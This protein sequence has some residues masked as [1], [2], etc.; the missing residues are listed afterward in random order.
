MPRLHT[1]LLL[2]FAGLPGCQQST[3]TGA[4]APIDSTFLNQPGTSDGTG[5]MP[6]AS[7]TFV[8]PAPGAPAMANPVVSFYARRGERREVRMV[9]HAAPGRS[10]STDFVR[11]RVDDRSLLT[12]P[13]GSP[14]AVGDSV[15]ITLT[16]V[17]AANLV[18]DF[19]PAGLR[20]NPRDPAELRFCFRETDP[21]LNQDGVVDVQDTLLMQRFQ[22]WRA[23]A[24][25]SQWTPTVST[26]SAPAYEVEA[27]VGGFTRYALAY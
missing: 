14:I 9:Y 18:V 26:V 3:Q 8:R 23:E 20:F 13:D 21:D 19:Q 4:T 27:A 5:T 25:G 10:D 22:L 7:P 17:D 6:S 12:R 11:F 15:L 16:L 1:I 2:T 24:A